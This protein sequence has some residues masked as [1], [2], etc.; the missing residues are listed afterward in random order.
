MYRM[1][2]LPLPSHRR[3]WR[4]TCP[5]VHGNHRRPQLRRMLHLAVEGEPLLEPDLLWSHLHCGR[6]NRS[7]KMTPWVFF[8]LGVM[9]GVLL[10]VVVLIIA[11][12]LQ[13]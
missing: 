12:H 9:T 4:E 13:K 8:F 3:A 5:L 7:D 2:V 11:F 10:S 1:S 6:V